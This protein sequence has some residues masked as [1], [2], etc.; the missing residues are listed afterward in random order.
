M[1]AVK[2]TMFMMVMMGGGPLVACVERPLLGDATGDGAS[3]TSTGVGVGETAGIPTSSGESGTAGPQPG[4]T[5]SSTEPQPGSTT[6][7]TGAESTTCGFICATTD[8]ASTDTS[9]DTFQQNCPEGEKCAAYNEGGSLWNATKCVPVTGDGQPG[10]PCSTMGGGVSGLDDCAKGGMCWDVDRTNIGVCREL[11]DFNDPKCSDE[12]KFECN[13]VTEV[14]SLCLPSCDPLIQDCP[15]DDLC[16][17]IGETFV[18][19]FDDSGEGGQVFDT[20]EFANACDKGLLC[21]NPTAADECEKLA[22]GCCMPLCDLSD[23]NVVC[24]GVGT[25]CVSL[26]EEGMAPPKYAN[27][28][29]CVVP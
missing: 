24:P 3:S 28:G 14:F 25:G 16:L 13:Y 17:P 29:I 1:G 2:R 22:G 12:A 26:Y 7:S 11:C 8:D 21:L 18:C 27:V 4:S 9:C 6:G 15:A 5:S 23:P 10:E 19:I 20:C